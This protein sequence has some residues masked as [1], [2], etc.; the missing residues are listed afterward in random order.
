[1]FYPCRRVFYTNSHDAFLIV[2]NDHVDH[3]LLVEI[4]N[5]LIETLL[6]KINIT[7]TKVVRMCIQNECLNLNVTVCH[8]LFRYIFCA[9]Y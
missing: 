1:M 8:Q 6:S 7:C 9:R 5:L 3:H 2:L 4:M